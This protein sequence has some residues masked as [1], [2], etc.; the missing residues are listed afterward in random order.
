M[1]VLVLGLFG[2]GIC[3]LGFV[4]VISCCLGLFDGLLLC[5][6][7]VRVVFCIWL[8]G[9]VSLLLFCVWMFGL[10]IVGLGLSV[11]VVWF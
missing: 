10:M 8:W 7:C 4:V 1:V 5:V 11:L 6:L 3:V 2:V 9:C